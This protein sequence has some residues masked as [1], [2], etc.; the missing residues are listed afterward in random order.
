MP[1]R[2]RLPLPSAPRPD[3]SGGEM[4]AGTLCVLGAAKNHHAY[5]RSGGYPDA[6]RPKG[7][8]KP[9]AT[10]MMDARHLLSCA[11]RTIGRIKRLRHQRL[12]SSLSCRIGRPLLK[13]PLITF[14]ITN[15]WGAASCVH[16]CMSRYRLFRSPFIS[17]FKTA[18]ADADTAAPNN[19]PIQV[20]AVSISHEADRQVMQRIARQRGG[21]VYDRDCR[22]GKRGPCAALLPKNI[23]AIQMKSK[24]MIVIPQDKVV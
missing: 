6:R 24:T 18:M 20:H 5:K 12:L 8:Y 16:S 9:I 11:P 1:S 3:R 13:T 14:A 19:C 23:R 7:R 2:L 4:Q 10:G 22:D 15:A 21:H 17:K